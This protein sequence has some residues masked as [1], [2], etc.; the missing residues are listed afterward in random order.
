MEQILL[1]DTS[2]DHCTVGLVRDAELVQ[3]LQHEERQSQAAVIN[4]LVEQLCK[5]AN[6]QLADLNAIAVCSGP[7]SYTGLRIG[8]AAAKGFAYALNKPLILHHKLELLAQQLMRVND[9]FW[10]YAVL[11]GAR[12]GEF[13]YAAY[14]A[15]MNI[16]HQPV[17]GTTEN[18]K[19]LIDELSVTSACLTGDQQAAAVFGERVLL[20]PQID[21]KLWAAWAARSLAMQNFADVATAVPFYMKEVFIYQP[22]DKDKK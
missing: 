9:D 8:M 17:H 21:F 11:I 6:I 12:P 18:I 5:E 1:I 2:A 15:E 16:I 14:D 20:A 7:G 3:A 4:P 10:Q 22:R 19:A 13:F